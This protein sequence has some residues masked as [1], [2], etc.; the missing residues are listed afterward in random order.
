MRMVSKGG[1]IAAAM[2]ATLAANLAAASAA[3]A[4]R[5]LLIG[6]VAAGGT[7]AIPGLPEIRRA[8]AQA[9]GM[10][11]RVYVAPDAARLIDAQA[12]GR[13]HY[14]IYSSAAYAAAAASCECVEPLAAPVGTGG[15]VGLQAVIY[16]RRGSAAAIEDAARLRVIS[17]PAQA[18]GPQLLA[19]EALAAA[20]AGD[21]VMFA[22]DFAS[23]E[24]AFA[25]G[26]ADVLVGWEA[27]GSVD[28]VIRRG[29]RE[30]MAALGVA[31]NEIVEL[32]RSGVVRYGPHAVRTDMPADLKASLRAFLLHV[33]AQQPAVYDRLEAHHLGGFRQ[34]SEADYA[35]AARMVL[36]A[37]E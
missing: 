10:Q 22:A 2:A 11:V 21:D 6:V 33:H 35:E 15:D 24:Q 34:V 4:P 17:G 8:Y 32:W 16:A 5:I 1:M 30:R 29:S 14:A 25:E 18:V 19:L 7:G 13:V 12:K 37:A 26:G 28:G 9:S 3:D 27:A 23:A 36:L 20:G 31:E